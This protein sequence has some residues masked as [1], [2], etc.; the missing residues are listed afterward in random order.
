[1]LAHCKGS[2]SAFKCPKQI[3]LTETIPRTATGKIQRRV[4]AEAFANKQ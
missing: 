4:V 3:H 1:L 2:L